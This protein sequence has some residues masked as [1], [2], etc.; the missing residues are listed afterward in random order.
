MLQSITN[1]VQFVPEVIYFFKG[2]VGDDRYKL[3]KYPSIVDN[4]SEYFVGYNNTNR[5]D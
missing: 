5:N 3:V 1:S 4:N 2:I